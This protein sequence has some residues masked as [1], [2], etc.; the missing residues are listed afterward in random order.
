MARGPEGRRP[1]GRT[2]V[3]LLPRAAVLV[4]RV[5]ARQSGMVDAL[6][7]ERLV[8]RRWQP[9]DGPAMA[10]ING[11]PEVTRYLNRVLDAAAVDGFYALMVGH[12]DL[13][14]F[15]PWVVESREAGR[16]GETLG[17]AGLAHLPPFLADAAAAVPPEPRRGLQRP[18]PARRAPRP[19]PAPGPSAA[20]TPGSAPAAAG[21]APTT[22][23]LPKPPVGPPAVGEGLLRP[24][25]PAG[26][27]LVRPRPRGP[28]PPTGPARS[29]RAAAPAQPAATPPPG[30]TARSAAP[31]GSMRARPGTPAAQARGAA[32]STYPT[33]SRISQA[34][35]SGVF[36][37]SVYRFTTDGSA[38]PSCPA[39]YTTTPHGTSSGSARN[40]PRNR[41]VPS[42]TATP[43]RVTASAPRPAQHHQFP[44]DLTLRAVARAGR[45]GTLA[46]RVG[47]RR[48][49]SGAFP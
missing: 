3:G 30:R 1:S 9:D 23:N 33:T 43:S 10:E 42:C 37:R 38:T 27:R 48:W 26:G 25:P 24:R 28:P 4:T 2:D 31:G 7:T 16:A 32:R 5:E 14:G 45:A 17:F 6:V 8:L 35:S 49:G 11:D 39:S 44:V 21:P 12:W 18:R 46:T 15:G 22:E 40:V 47:G 34:C 19:A 36:A 13:Y 41:A 29:P 20:R